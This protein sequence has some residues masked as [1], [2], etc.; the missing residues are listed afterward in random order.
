MEDDAQDGPDHMDAHRIPAFAISPYTRRGAVIHTRYDF[1]SLIRTLQIPIGMKPLT[2]FDRLATPLSA[3]FPRT[4]ANAAPF[5]AVAPT[6][7]LT[8]RVPSTAKT[9][10]YARRYPLTLTPPVE[11]P[12]LGRMLG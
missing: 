10:S 3:A 2:L 8:T 1:P 5:N 4:P 12:G 7:S 6:T 11:Q 9:R